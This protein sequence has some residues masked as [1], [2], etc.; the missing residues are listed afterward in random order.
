[1]KL[2]RRVS[3]SP[4]F[5]GGH[6]PTQLPTSVIC[7]FILVALLACPAF[8]DDE[9][10]GGPNTSRL[11]F[12]DIAQNLEWA[13]VAVAEED[14]TLWGASPII[15]DD[16]KT[17]LFVARWPQ[18]NVDPAWRRSSEI[19]HY[20]ASAPEGPFHFREVVLQG[21]GTD[22]WDR[23]AP[24]NPEIRKFGDTYAL[25]YIANDDYHRP[26]HPL[27]QSIGLAV[28]K[29]LDGPWEKAGNNGLLLTAS[30]DPQHWTHGRQVV[31]PTVIQVGDKYHLYFKSKFKGHTAYGLATAASFQGPF[32]MED[33]PITGQGLTLED[34][35]AFQWRDHVYLLTT[36]N[37][38]DMTG[39]VGGGTLWASPDGRRFPSALAQVG[40]DLLSRYRPGYDATKVRRVYGNRPKLERPKVLMV[41]DRPA[42]LYG[43]SGW[44]IHG[45]DRCAVYVLRIGLAE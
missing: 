17:H 34:A 21:T 31:N 8:A 44:T 28:S 37:R 4:S 19:A 10:A 2:P 24:H 38:G 43:P 45:G 41:D 14:F 27:N 18:R 15:G 5:I 6:A 30:E 29:S 32:T 42:Y 26:P 9:A 16:G 40:F 25:F 20:V 13:G 22:T 1:M 12:S 33:E 35:T 23:Y 11:P 7:T 36:D 3:D 39:I